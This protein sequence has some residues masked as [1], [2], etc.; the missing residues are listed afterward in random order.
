MCLKI[1]E[2]KDHVESHST[3]SKTPFGFK[4]ISE[5]EMEEELEHGIFHI[6]SGLVG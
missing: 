3:A 2:I 1:I 4:K 5:K 6:L